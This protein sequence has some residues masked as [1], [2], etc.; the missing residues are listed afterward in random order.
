MR[1]FRD[2][3]QDAKQAIMKRYF[4]SEI[5]IDDLA[6]EYEVNPVSFLEYVQDQTETTKR[7]IAPEPELS[8]MEKVSITLAKM[9]DNLLTDVLVKV[10]LLFFLF[11]LFENVAKTVAPFSTPLAA[12]A[13]EKAGIALFCFLVGKLFFEAFTAI[14][15]RQEW[16]YQTPFLRPDF[17]FDNDFTNLT[18]YQRC[19]LSIVKRSVRMLI[20][21][22][23]FLGIL[24]Q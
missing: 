7:I 6:R 19:L 2:L 4:G 5:S 16:K 21:A 20:Y 17:G 18:P 15:D 10:V 1:N 9:R 12:L 13:I 14:T 23:L 22:L 3:S 8:A 11:F 24:M